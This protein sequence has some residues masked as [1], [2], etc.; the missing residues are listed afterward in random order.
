MSVA[1][2]NKL[3]PI[4]EKSIVLCMTNEKKQRETHYRFP[5]Y[6]SSLGKGFMTCL[7][8][9]S[10]SILVDIGLWTAALI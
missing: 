9:T 6:L 1:K 7:F 2:S 8:D 3:R 4:D 5:S 10:N